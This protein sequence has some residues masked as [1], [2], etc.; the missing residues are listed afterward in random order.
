MYHI[1]GCHYCLK[2]SV[3]VPF[4][5]T[6]FYRLTSNGVLFTISQNYLATSVNALNFAS[7]YLVTVNSSLVNK[8]FTACH[9]LIIFV[10]TLFSISHYCIETQVVCKLF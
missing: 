6:R 10:H 9:Y 3:K 1:T 7:H 4:T 8:L 5:A 2:T